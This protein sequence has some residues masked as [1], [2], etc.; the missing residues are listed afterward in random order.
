VDLL[1]DKCLIS[2]E[3][4]AVTTL[5][6]GSVCSSLEAQSRAAGPSCRDGSREAMVHCAALR[7]SKSLFKGAVIRSKVVSK[8]QPRP[9]GQVS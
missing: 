8:K 4:A 3:M 7:S 5:S 2:A 9:V 6:L 1:E